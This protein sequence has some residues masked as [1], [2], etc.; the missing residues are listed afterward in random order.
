MIKKVFDFENKGYIL[1]LVGALILQVLGYSMYIGGNG[2]A[3]GKTLWHDLG[4]YDVTA[5]GIDYYLAVASLI[6]VIFGFIFKSAWAFY[7]CFIWMTTLT[8]LTWYQGGSFGAPYSLFA[9]SNRYLLP[10]CLGY[11]MYARNKPEISTQESIA[12][13]NLVLTIAIAVVF[14]AHGLEAINKNPVFIDYSLK[15]VRDYIGIGIKENHA[16]M[17]LLLVGIQDILLALA[18][19][20][21]PNKW[22]LA[23]MAFWGAWT[24]ALRTLYSPSY[25]F[26]STLIRAANAAVPLVLCLQ[27]FKI[28]GFPIATDRSVLD[29]LSRVLKRFK[30]PS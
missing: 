11:W 21:K 30:R 8:F 4:V 29:G 7:F 20:W 5:Y 27:Y 26:P 12:N 10:A 28:K 1:V 25:G 18:I 14:I 13:M 22:V 16:V 23:Y 19:L 6:L 9:H 15:F 2:S 24:A 3:V 17:L